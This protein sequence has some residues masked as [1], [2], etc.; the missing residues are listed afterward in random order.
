MKTKFWKTLSIVLA[1][2]GL[3][4]SVYFTALADSYD[5]Q[6][7][8][9]QPKKSKTIKKTKKVVKEQKPKVVVKKVPVIKKVKEKVPVTKTKVVTKEVPK[10]IEKDKITNTNTNNNT[11]NNQQEQSQSQ[12]QSQTVNVTQ[13]A[14]TPE[15]TVV[16]R[17]TVKRDV[18][19]VRDE[20]VAPTALPET[21]AEPTSNNIIPATRPEQLLPE[22]GPATSIAF[23]ATSLIGSIAAY[24]RSKKAL[25][26]AHRIK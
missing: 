8:K 3:A 24:T 21:G 5:T 11:N 14:P 13:A 4:G 15:R 6:P 23:G 18:G 2:L 17:E 26:N 25:S 10:E 22:A 7:K 16:E 9:T 19:K 1:G 12:N 20:T